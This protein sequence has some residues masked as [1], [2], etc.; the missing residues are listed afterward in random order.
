MSQLSPEGRAFVRATRS[1]DEPTDIDE[2]R[3][4][5][6]T[7]AAIAAA[8]AATAAIP[9]KAALASVPPVA[10]P[11]V[12]G[13]AIIGALLGVVVVGTGAAVETVRDRAS[14]GSVVAGQRSPAPRAARPIAPV[15]P[16]PSSSPRP[17]PEAAKASGIPARTPSSPTGSSGADAL[18]APPS[19]AE[20]EA[21][22]L[23][24]LRE[25]QEALRVL[26]ERQ[27]ARLIEACA[28]GGR[29]ARAE[30]AR[31]LQG[32]PASPLTGRIT[33]ACAEEKS[34]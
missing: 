7:L 32:R 28:G 10:A 1:L 6:K 5:K 9:A 15:R 29:E 12:L 18:A 19:S 4:R 8:S 14:A 24:M 13:G 23:A 2:A 31:F 30:A 17:D 25:A 22:E 11:G 26:E 21:R 33:A 34:E 20:K 16:E 3:I 27:A